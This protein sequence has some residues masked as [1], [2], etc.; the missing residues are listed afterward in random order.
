M[1]KDP[2][3][4]LEEF[5]KNEEWY[6]AHFSE[7]LKKCQNKFV[8][9]SNESIAGVDKDIVKLR[10]KL[11][12]KRIDICPVYVEYVTNKPLDLILKTI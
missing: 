2:I 12:K 11:E 1:C 7:L 3:I 8:A 5:K 4:H 10:N 6:S 9:I